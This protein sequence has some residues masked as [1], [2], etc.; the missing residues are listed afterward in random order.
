MVSDLL[1]ADGQWDE[2][3]IRQVAIL[4][5]PARPRYEDV[6]TWEPEKHGVYS[7][8]SAYRLLDTKRISDN[9]VNV[10]CF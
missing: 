3:A 9:D 1:L 4:R 8:R 2:D 10:K 5:T 6:W 7:V